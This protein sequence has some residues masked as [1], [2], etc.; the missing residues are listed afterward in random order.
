MRRRGIKDKRRIKKRRK[1][2][3]RR[4]RKSRFRHRI[5]KGLPI[6]DVKGRNGRTKS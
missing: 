1:S 6:D 4:K 5:K 2:K 3:K